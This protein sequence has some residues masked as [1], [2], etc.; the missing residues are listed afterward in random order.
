[1]PATFCKNA[2]GE[3]EWRWKGLPVPRPIYALD[4]L[5]ERCTVRKVSSLYETEPIDCPGPE[6]FLNAAAH[7]ETALN[8]RELLDF[9]G[10]DWDP[11]CLRFHESRR[12]TKTASRDQVR[13]PIYTS[14][15][16][17]W[18]NYERHLEPL[19]EALSGPDRRG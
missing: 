16:G 1:M 12:F 15:S 7:I 2:K 14:S 19:K 17:R 11:A 6:R 18:Q 13:K 4:R 10:L 9:L 3:T 5:A 8:P